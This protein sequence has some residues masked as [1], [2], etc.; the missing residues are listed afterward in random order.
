MTRDMRIPADIMGIKDLSFCEKGILAEMV[1][2]SKLTGFCF[3]RI[4]HFESRFGMANSTVR[5]VIAKLVKDGYIDKCGNNYAPKIGG[6]TPESGA[7]E[8]SAETPKIGGPPPKSSGKAPKIGGPSKSLINPV[9]NPK[10]KRAGAQEVSIRP[11]ILPLAE[12]LARVR[13]EVAKFNGPVRKSAVVYYAGLVEKILANGEVQLPQVHGVVRWLDTHPN[14]RKSFGYGMVN[15]PK[16][17]D[18]SLFRNFAQCLTSARADL[19]GEGVRKDDSKDAGGVT[20]RE[21]DLSELN[22]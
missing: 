22:D 9:S 5:S 6:N 1:H 13:H 16:G 12:T 7:P 18:H 2:L 4:A 19:L 17:Y 15:T 11:E 8:I 14:G 10:D 21:F 3:A 20:Y